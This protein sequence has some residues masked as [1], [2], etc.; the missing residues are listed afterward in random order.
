MEVIAEHLDLIQENLIVFLS[1]VVATVSV[2]AGVLHLH[3]KGQTAALKATNETLREQRDGAQQERDSIKSQR[4]DLKEELQKQ[5]AE[6]PQLMKLKDRFEEM[7]SSFDARINE[8]PMLTEGSGA[9]GP[10]KDDGVHLQ[11]SGVILNELQ[12]QILVY[13]AGVPNENP[14][15]DRIADDLGVNHVR[16]GHALDR[17]LEQRLLGDTIS[18]HGH[19]FHLAKGG[20]E[21][22]V[23]N[24]L[25][26]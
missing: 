17:L 14:R 6:E 25:I 20:R 13:L 12:R 4:D 3:Y 23:T 22:L 19:R 2:T 16:V 9:D 7:S 18:S 8:L 10:L 1:V 24:D 26:E 21:Y 5:A 11:P 15:A